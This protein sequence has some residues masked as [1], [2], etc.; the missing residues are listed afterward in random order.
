MFIHLGYIQAITTS[1]ANN[2]GII[3]LTNLLHLEPSNID[4][5]CKNIQCP[6]STIA[7]CNNQQVPNLGMPNSTMAQSNLKLMTFWIMH[8]LEHAQCP[9]TPL[10]VT[11]AVIN[12]FKGQQKTKDTYKLPTE[13]QTSMRRTG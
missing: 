1:I 2:H 8:H 7:G 5:L 12:P 9:T 10:D 3:T 11:H 4:T 6:G 13:P